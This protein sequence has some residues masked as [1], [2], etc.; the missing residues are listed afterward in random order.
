M[1]GERYSSHLGRSRVC[2]RDRDGEVS[3]ARDSP[4]KEDSSANPSVRSMI[5]SVGVDAA[6]DTDLEG[7]AL[8]LGCR[9][10]FSSSSE[11][12]TYITQDRIFRR[13]GIGC[14]TVNLQVQI[15]RGVD[16]SDIANNA[17]WRI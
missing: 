10:L 15:G 4:F 16:D 7:P 11:D 3:R 8:R 17:K 9:F 5:S 13:S 14:I 2:E 1:I 12:M 6:G